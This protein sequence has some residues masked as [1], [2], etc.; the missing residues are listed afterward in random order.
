M[1]LGRGQ[2]STAETFSGFAVNSSSDM[3]SRYLTFL[4][5]KEYFLRLI[6]KLAALNQRR[7]SCKLT[8]IPSKVLPK[9]IT[10]SK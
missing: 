3:Y 10:S 6:F 1:F 2:F 9:I 7:I 8:N 4:L 5:K